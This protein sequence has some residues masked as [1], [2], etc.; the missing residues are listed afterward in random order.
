MQLQESN[1]RVEHLSEQN[2]ALK[3]LVQSHILSDRGLNDDEILDTLSRADVRLL[4]MNELVTT[5]DING[6]DPF[7]MD[8]TNNSMIQSANSSYHSIPNV[9]NEQNFTQ[10]RPLVRE[11][12][13]SA[14]NLLEMAKTRDPTSIPKPTRLK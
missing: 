8:S 4:E 2:T 12:T 6:E 10:R 9:G 1:N 5:E 14:C 3:A 11:L 13:P 7:I